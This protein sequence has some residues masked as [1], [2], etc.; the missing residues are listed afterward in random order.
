MYVYQHLLLSPYSQFHP[1]IIGVGRRFFEIEAVCTIAHII[2][3]YS[4]HYEALPG[5]T[6]AQSQE[7]LLRATNGIT[8]TPYKVPLIF[9]KRVR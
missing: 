7:R 3:E 8:F 4:I 9:K 1:L 2:H 6:R 5:E